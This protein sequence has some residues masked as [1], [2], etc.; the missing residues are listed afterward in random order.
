MHFTKLD[1][2]FYMAAQGDQEAFDYLYKEFYF[3]ARH[4]IRVLLGNQ[5]NYPGNPE[6]FEDLI[7]SYFCSVVNNFDPIR[8]TFSSYMDYVCKVR[9][10]NQVKDIII[11]F[12][13]KTAE[14]EPF[15]DEITPVEAIQDPNQIPM[16]SDIAINGFKYKIASP[17]KDKTNLQRIRDKIILLQYA[18]YSNLE[19]CKHLHMTYSQLR[20]HLS[21]IK[22]QRD[23]INLKLDLK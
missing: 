17:R 2:Y 14:L 1:A 22:E 13:Q 7:D 5:P 21:H 4:T 8:R 6:D 16:T 10:T 23:I 15:F 9:L 20:T 3:R 18:G 19:I 12:I 11:R